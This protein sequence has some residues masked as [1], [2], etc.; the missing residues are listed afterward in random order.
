MNSLSKSKFENYSDLDGEQLKNLIN[1]WYEQNGR[2]P[3]SF[4]ERTREK[5]TKKSPFGSVT[6]WDRDGC[7]RML[8]CT[9][10]LEIPAV[11]EAD[12]KALPRLYL[13]PST[14]TGMGVEAH[15]QKEL[16]YNFIPNTNWVVS[17]SDPGASPRKPDLKIIPIL[18]NY[19][20]PSQYW[21][22]CISPVLCPLR[23]N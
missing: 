20:H 3:R 13:A 17:Y 15:G 21:R 2:A 22:M 11:N 4:R 5:T 9:H 1:L 7:A 18:R 10:S 14:Q 6:S 23:S 16:K 12:V 19:P 8:S